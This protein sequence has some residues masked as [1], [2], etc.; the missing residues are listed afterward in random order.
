MTM[1][2]EHT[3]ILIS[4]ALGPEGHEEYTINEELN[5]KHI[6]MFIS[7]IINTNFS[8]ADRPDIHYTYKRMNI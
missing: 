5:P 7:I 6:L 1:K 2:I 8:T 3:K 4:S